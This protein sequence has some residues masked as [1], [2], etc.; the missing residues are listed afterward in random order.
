MKNRPCGFQDLCGYIPGKRRDGKNGKGQTLPTE[1]SG[2]T[3]VTCQRYAASVLKSMNSKIH[4]PV[5]GPEGCQGEQR[6]QAWSE[7]KLLGPCLL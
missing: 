1:L 3:H 7:M 4:W 2:E 5:T 6:R